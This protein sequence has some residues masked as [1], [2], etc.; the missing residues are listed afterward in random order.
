MPQSVSQATL[1]PGTLLAKRY[2]IEEVIGSGG[3]ASVYRATD[4]TFKLPRAIKEVTDQD[5][6]VRTQFQLEAE[7]LINI[8][9]DNIPHGYHLIE[10]M[11]RMYLIMEYVRGKDL[12]ELLNE[13]LTQRGRPLEEA[14]VL[15]W[16]IEICDALSVM[17]ALDT[18]I[19]H[20]D[21][22][23]ANI[24]ITPE[25][26]PVLIDFGLAKLQQRGGGNP[27]MTAAQGVSPGFAPPEQY[28]A[29]GRT[30]A[31]TDLYGLGAT[32]YACLTG[33][34]PAE[35][36]A[37][38]LA[39]TGVSN[40][41]ASLVPLRRLNPRISDQTERVVIKALELS[42]SQR[43]QSAKQLRNELNAALMALTG[44]AATNAAASAS[45][46]A[47]AV[48]GL[49]CP[50]C[51][52]QNRPEVAQCVQCGYPLRSGAGQGMGEGSGKRPAVPAPGGPLRGG[53][54]KQPAV[55]GQRPGMA[56]VAALGA[57]A[58]V[59]IAA[60]R[61]GKHLA[62]TPDQRSGKQPAVSPNQRSGKQPIITPP[63]APLPM[64]QAA[65]MSQRSGKQLAVTPGMAARGATGKQ[66]TLVPQNT[67]AM[68]AMNG[69]A[70]AVAVASK[71]A[72]GGA[73][74]ALAMPPSSNSVALDPGAW[75]RLGSTPLSGFGKWFL[76]L[77]VVEAL[78]GAAVITLGMMT[79]TANGR[80]LPLLQLGIGWLVGVA[81]L[82]VLGGQ[83]LSR[84]IYRRG[85]L[86]AVRRGLQGFALA[87]FTIVV[88]G[89]ALWGAS[90]FASS[91][92]N[93]TL[94]IFAYL[95]FGVNVLIVGVLSVINMLA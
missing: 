61:S 95:V 44:Q 43:Q 46:P 7:L 8:K 14:Q 13:S 63:A 70:G 54:G 67:G 45:N 29:K 53:S 1:A 6:G 59:G 4:L 16:A 90:I 19:I 88:H 72:R 81:I 24:K 11:G 85:K 33:K 15:R 73:S 75:I 49:I 5:R 80:T 12:E 34:D 93:A 71:P 40:S 32:I 55:G 20:R 2:R 31:R 87:L 50:H 22:K 84:P 42:S 38:L 39:Q 74:A 69:G 68:L 52:V 78:W 82:S 35:A 65:Q 27:T 86:P 66:A 91:Q 62:V 18:P 23:P 3:Y 48:M 26:R 94:A 77:S 10:E 64:G 56:G 57:G 92:P 47:T 25:D 37:R 83:A 9:Q 28:M 51:G 30:D 76:A 58:A 41:G 79:L 36:P 89:V 17:H 60:Q 21:I